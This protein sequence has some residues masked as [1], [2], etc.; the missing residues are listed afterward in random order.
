YHYNRPAV[1]NQLGV[2]LEN[3]TA[4][5]MGKMKL[6]KVGEENFLGY[7]CVKYSMKNDEMKMDV[8]Y[9]TYGNLMMKM[10]G[11]MMEIPTSIEVAKIEAVTPPADKFEIPAGVTITEQ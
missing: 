3:I 10:S 5:I 8:E 6:E 1:I 4:D 11:K 9:L 2:D 7:P